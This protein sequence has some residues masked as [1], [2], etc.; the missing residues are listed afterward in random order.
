MPDPVTPR[1][2]A[3]IVLLSGGLDSTVLLYDTM[4]RGTDVRALSVDYGQRHR[5]EIASAV[6]IAARANVLEHQVAN[7]AALVPLLAGSSQTSP[8]LPVPEGHYTDE[9]MKQTVVPNRNMLLLALAGAWAVSTQ[10][11]YIAYAAHSGDHPIYPDCRPAFIQAMGVALTLANDHKVHL[12]SPFERSTKADIVARGAELGVPFELTWS[13]Y[14]G[15]ELH[16]G[17]CGTCV[18]RREA[19]DLSGVKDPTQYVQA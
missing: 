19:F 2:T 10:S 7:L 11:D 15:E 16:C 5:C 6:M 14:K 9:S 17:K 8:G 4:K 3:T 1:R 18:E 12:L 13:C